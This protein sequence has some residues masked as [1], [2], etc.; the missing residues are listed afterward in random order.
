MGCLRFKASATPSTRLNVIGACLNNC[1]LAARVCR[2]PDWNL[3]RIRNEFAKP[4]DLRRARVLR[5]AVSRDARQHGAVPT[6]C[7]ASLSSPCKQQPLQ[8]IVYAYII[9]NMT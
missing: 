7:D 4:L 3:L 6:V 1:T 8:C 9:F 2:V 5:P